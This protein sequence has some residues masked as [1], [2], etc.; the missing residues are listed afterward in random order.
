MTIIHPMLAPG[1][2]AIPMFRNSLL[3]SLANT[4]ALGLAIDIR[5]ACF[6]GVCP[7]RGIDRTNEV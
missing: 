5:P 3:A 6:F 7:L 4:L 2:R 1:F